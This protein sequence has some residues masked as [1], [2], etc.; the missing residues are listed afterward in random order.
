MNESK[1]TLCIP[2]YNE[3]KVVQEALE[4]LRS[5]FPRAEIIVVDDGST[6]ET[7]TIAGRVKGVT[8]ITHNRN[9]G[10]GAALKTAMRHSS[11][12]VIAWCDGDGQHHRQ[13]QVCT[14]PA[15]G[16]RERRLRAVEKHTCENVPLSR[17]K[18]KVFLPPVM[19]NYQ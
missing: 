4:R 14:L 11:G 15:C 12:A 18:Q 19:Q 9:S 17:T 6:D 8:V 16:N 7:A 3:E 1:L 13:T 10:Y 5:R 2:V